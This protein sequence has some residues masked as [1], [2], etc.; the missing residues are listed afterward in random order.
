MIAQD[1]KVEN[2]FQGERWAVGRAVLQAW[3]RGNVM[4]PFPNSTIKHELA[5][6]AGMTKLQVDDWLLNY[7]RRHWD[8]DK[9]QCNLTDFLDDLYG[10]L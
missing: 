9:L 10:R 2:D 1:S 5:G 7:R 6:M 4:H 3:A 8:A